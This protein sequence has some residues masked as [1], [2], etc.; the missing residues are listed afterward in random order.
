ME[1]A[2]GV[3]DKRVA[4]KFWW[5]LAKYEKDY[6]DRKKVWNWASEW[7]GGYSS[8]V[9]FSNNRFYVNS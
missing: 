2:K 4:S 3:L 6:R 7:I 5:V 1:L 9:E 8:E